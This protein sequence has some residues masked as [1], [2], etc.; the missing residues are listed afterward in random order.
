VTVGI[1]VG[2]LAR[3]VAGS[4]PAAGLGQ[5]AGVP[6]VA[7][8]AVPAGQRPRKRRMSSTIHTSSAR[9]MP[10]CRTVSRIGE[11]VLSPIRRG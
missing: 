2:L 1:T 11:P 6:G 7:A 8:V 10:I 9:A 3:E 5:S 4:D